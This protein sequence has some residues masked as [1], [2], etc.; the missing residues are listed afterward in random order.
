MSD[1]TDI[2][3]RRPH[4]FF[5]AMCIE[6]RH[7]WVAV[8]RTNVLLKDLECPDCKLL[9]RVINTGQVMEE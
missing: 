3:E 9:G 2:T 4:M 5:E 1:V 7:R 8:T 6:C